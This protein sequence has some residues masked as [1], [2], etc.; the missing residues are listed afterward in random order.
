MLGTLGDVVFEVNT[1]KVRTWQDM[2][3]TYKTSYA[4]HK[5]LGRGVMLEFTGQEATTCTFTLRLDATHGLSPYQEL[6]ALRKMAREH[7][8]IDFVIGGEPVGSGEWVIEELDVSAERFAIGG[9]M[10][11][12]VVNVRLREYL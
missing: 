10:I 1:D 4:E 12:S 11:L 6:M 5:I 8:A 9:E 3:F 7:Q 2:A